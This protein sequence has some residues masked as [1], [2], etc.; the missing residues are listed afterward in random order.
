MALRP[1]SRMDDY[2]FPPD[3]W[4]VR[5]WSVRTDVDDERV[6]RVDD[7]LLDHE[8]S[9]R[10]LDVDVGYLKRHVLVPLDRAYADRQDETVRIEGLV[11]EQVEDVP[12]YALDPETLDE[13]YERRL[14]GFYRSVPRSEPAGIRDRAD[15][16]DGELDLRRMEALED[17]YDI[18]GDDPRGWEVV[19]ADGREAG[20]V[21]E[22]LM[23][24]G[25][26]RARFLDVV[27]DE[28]ELDLEPVDR[29]ILLPAERVR[30]DRNNKKV[31]VSGLFAADVADYPRYG[32]MPVRR[33][34]AYE[35]DEFF[36]RAADPDT[37]R[38][39]DELAA[40]RGDAVDVETARPI[41]DRPRERDWSDRT[42]RHFYG[43][44]G[45]RSTRSTRRGH[46]G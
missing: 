15:D 16:L 36:D 40:D 19:T 11:K 7:M 12:E 18:A 17:D 6:G 41:G 24:P 26:M 34:T 13:D 2:S 37:A 10:Y 27:V 23:D 31:V 43:S 29:H 1:I 32:G 42:L 45:R 30:L 28:K 8:G 20:E 21:A 35:L 22:L 33:R 4:D 39:S 5:G 3:A 25:E 46:H 14:D 44:S 9:L 38:Q